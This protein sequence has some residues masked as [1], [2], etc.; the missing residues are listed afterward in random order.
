MINKEK[1][2][3]ILDSNESIITYKADKDFRCLT[4]T[5]KT[6]LENNE[7]IKEYIEQLERTIKEISK[8]QTHKQ[9]DYCMHYCNTMIER[10]YLLDERRKLIEKLE[11]D[12]ENSCRGMDTNIILI[13]EYYKNKKEYAQEI[14]E[15]L[16]GEENE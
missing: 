2:E 5:E 8:Q 16:K 7:K 9:D 14:L 10:K 4:I 13:K 11:E 1:I 12:I 6:L 15:I 3:N